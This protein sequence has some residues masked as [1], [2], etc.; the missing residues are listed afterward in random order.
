MDHTMID[1]TGVPGVEIGS[2]VEVMGGTSMGAEEMARAC[3]TIPYEIL[4]QV[5]SRIPR[6]TID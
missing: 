5:G 6:A 4:V 3:G 1:V 2:G